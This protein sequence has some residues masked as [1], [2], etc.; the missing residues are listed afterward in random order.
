MA[1][2]IKVSEIRKQ[3][4]MYA[5]L[6]DQ[7][8]LSGIRKKYYSDIPFGKFISRIEFD[9]SKVDP[10]EG[11]SGAQKFLAGAGKAL[12]DTARG[13]GQLVGAVSRED[14]AES[15]RLD[16]ALMRSGAA[17]AGN[18]TGNIAATLPAMLVPGAATLKGAAAIGAA[19]GFV[20]PS[21]STGETVTNAAL[22]G[23]LAP[24]AQVAGRVVGAG[25]ETARGL[26]EPLTKAGQ[27]RIAQRTLQQ[28]AGIAP[29]A[30]Q[31]A[32]SALA[33]ARSAVPGVIPT[34]AQAAD[35][36]GIAQLES[37]ISRMPEYAD[38]FRQR[39]SSNY[40]AIA[41]AMREV[42]GDEGQRAFFENSRDIAAKQLYKTAYQATPDAT[43]LTPAIKGEITK[44]LKRPSVNQA[45]KVAQ[46][47]A[48]ERGEK[49]SANGSLR[50][51]HDVKTALDDDI[52]AAVQAGRGGEVE[53]LRAT[54][55]KLLN[56]M[57][58]LSPTYGE[59]RATYAEMSKPINQLDVGQ[60][61]YN[62]LFSATS[63]LGAERM[64]P[65]AFANALR[66]ADAT[67][68]RA[69]GF[70]SAKMADVMSPEQMQVINN[71]AKEIGSRARADDLLRSV[72]SNTMQNMTSQNAL[73]AALGPTG[74]PETV[75]DK[76]ASSALGQLV[77]SP[78][79]AIG[80]ISG[81]EKRAT[82]ILANALLDPQAAA[83]LL[84]RVEQPS[85][86]NRAMPTVNRLL[87]Y[88]PLPAIA[89]GAQQ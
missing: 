30:Q 12:V 82:D 71:V 26:I 61:L 60:E 8:L 59:A 55:Q 84:Q 76:F 9:T 89:Y 24:G 36:R 39:S 31:Q 27:E 48:I 51:L 47:W 88:A 70:P 53:A 37:A 54:Q 72:G 21:V 67:A 58:K 80:A 87:G 3:F 29:G 74:L 19:T 20:Q 68:A 41:D 66:N 28:F 79:R 11:M 23:V 73:R 85:L 78:A 83:A 34:A 64:T 49:P 1:N 62:R 14:V 22:G 40:N 18:L 44:L 7:Q 6:D 10:T 65:N 69:T 45:S 43:S 42:A 46:R 63:D 33:S 2:K 4:P 17:Q 77:A 16:E 5:D 86:V 56:V 50:A 38:L 75:L 57:E 25:A 52:T 32:A 35:N 81:A 15:R 13:V